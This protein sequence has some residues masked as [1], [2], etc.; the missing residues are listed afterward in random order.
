MSEEKKYC[1]RFHDGNDSEGRPIV[2]LWKRLIIRET[3]KTFWHVDDFPYM[4]FEQV[5]SY[6]TRGRK[7]DQKRYIKRCAKGAD[8]S[9]YH[10]TKE[11]ALKAFIYRKRYQ[12]ERIRL[13]AETVSLILKGLTDAGH[14]AYS[15]DQHG[16]QKRNIVSVPEVECFVASE[17]PGPIAS[18][19]S[20]G[21][22]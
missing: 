1:Y 5:V 17:E 13:T 11:E 15:T 20:W 21:E 2:T 16:F 3:D 9:R 7:E 18:T 12:L 14:V 10:Y 19:Y 4:S 22:Y 6:W 8:R